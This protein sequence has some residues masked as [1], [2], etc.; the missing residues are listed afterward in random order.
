MTLPLLRSLSLL[1]FFLNPL[2]P[3]LV[4]PL[5]FVQALQFP[6]FK[7]QW[8]VSILPDL[9]AA[10]TQLITPCFSEH[11]LTGCTPVFPS[12]SPAAVSQTHWPD[13]FHFLHLL[14]SKF[15]SA[16]GLYCQTSS[17]FLSAQ[18]PRFFILTTW[19]CISIR[20]SLLKSTSS[21]LIATQLL[22]LDVW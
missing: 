6:K 14:T 22:H 15:W 5:S 3:E 12:L 10:L 21:C 13:I 8:Y 1:P 17:L 11:P 19:I 20:T 7:S 18:V 4:S 16:P 9:S 2:Q